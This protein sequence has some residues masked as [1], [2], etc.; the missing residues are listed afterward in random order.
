MS[1]KLLLFLSFYFVLFMLYIVVCCVVGSQGVR[2][3]T[4]Q[5]Y[6][7]FFTRCEISFALACFYHLRDRAVWGLPHDVLSV[8]YR[9]YAK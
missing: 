2:H 7:L 6:T 5:R 3:L 9:R 4:L 8:S 1:F